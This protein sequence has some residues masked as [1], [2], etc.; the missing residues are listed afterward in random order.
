MADGRCL[1]ALQGPGVSRVLFHSRPLQEERNSGA[2]HGAPA[3]CCVCAHSLGI[4]R[5]A[6]AGQGAETGVSVLHLCVYGFRFLQRAQPMHG[7]FL[8]CENL[9]SLKQCIFGCLNTGFPQRFKWPDISL[10][11]YSFFF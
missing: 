5:E 6:V 1:E 4:P 8:A 3:T 11:T 2:V 7:I 9:L 10:L